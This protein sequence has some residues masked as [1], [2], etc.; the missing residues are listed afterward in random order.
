M[1]IKNKDGYYLKNSDL[2]KEII[3][4]KKN[5]VAS[6]TLGRYLLLIA[7]NLSTKGNFNG[8]TWR[9][10]MVSE[11]VLTCIKY[12]K[13]FKPNKANAFAYVT[14]ICRHS[15]I[16]YIKAE[17]KHSEIKDRCYKCYNDLVIISVDDE[18]NQPNKKAIDYQQFG[19]KKRKNVE[20]NKQKQNNI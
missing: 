9:T 13:N 16:A 8:Y 12:L 6:E 1:K 10:D 17:R 20:K 11:A 19:E 3:D 15:F 5:N 4:F 7:T 18:D 2:V 14:Q